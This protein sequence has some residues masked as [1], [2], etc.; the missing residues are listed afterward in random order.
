MLVCW[1]ERKYVHLYILVPVKT[2]PVFIGCWLLPSKSILKRC[3]GK[4]ENKWE[5]QELQQHLKTWKLSGDIKGC[6]ELIYLWEWS[7][8]NIDKRDFRGPCNRIV[9]KKTLIWFSCLSPCSP[10]QA[11]WFPPGNI[12]VTQNLCL[13]DRL[14]TVFNDQL[15]S[16]IHCHSSWNKMA[17]LLEDTL[18]R[19][20]PL[21]GQ[22]LPK[23]LEVKPALECCPHPHGLW[24]F[25]P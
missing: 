25:H 21:I 19:Q 13:D 10:W 24:C 9:W 20:P 11:F 22:L 14:K 4:K 2:A 16:G 7:C 8:Y 12:N 5:F 15:P 23:C 3:R 18:W 1:R 17:G 6:F